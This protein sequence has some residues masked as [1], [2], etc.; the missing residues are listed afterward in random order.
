MG[1]R[2]RPSTEVLI[3][4]PAEGLWSPDA[5]SNMFTPYPISK[6]AAGYKDEYVGLHRPYVR[7]AISL[8]AALSTDCRAARRTLGKPK[9][10]DV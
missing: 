1:L 5:L 10:R 6:Y 8:A 3:L 2:P 7:R 4:D 9:G